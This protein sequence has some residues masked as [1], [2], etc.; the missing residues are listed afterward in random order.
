MTFGGYTLASGGGQQY[1]IVLRLPQTCRGRACPCPPVPSGAG[2]VAI[3]RC[4]IG[5]PPTK[6]YRRRA[7]PGW[8][9][10]CVARFEDPVHEML[11]APSGTG[12][13]AI[14]RCTIGRP[15]TKCYRRLA[16]PGMV[17]N[18]FLDWKTPSTKC[19]RRLATPGMVANAFLDWKAVSEMLPAP[20]GT[21]GQGQALPLQVWSGSDNQLYFKGGIELPDLS[22]HLRGCIDTESF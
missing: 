16:T 8:L 14:L 1:W 4:T 6:C 3:L 15:S 20:G 19:Y 13:V 9:R 12:M 7:A 21:G 22:D 11:P 18:A 2:M 17:A 10:F 5:R